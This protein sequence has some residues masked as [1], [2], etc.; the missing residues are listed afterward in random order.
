MKPVF[1]STYSHY[2]IVKKTRNL[3]TGPSFLALLILLSCYR[4]LCLLF[5]FGCFFE[6]LDL[7]FQS[8]DHRVVIFLHLLDAEIKTF[9]LLFELGFYAVFL[10]ACL[11]NLT[12]HVHAKLYLGSN[13]NDGIEEFVNFGCLEINFAFDDHDEFLL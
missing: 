11:G 5:F 3:F 4:L 2:T 13:S 12:L 9:A 6:L 8:L 1:H 10:P 7:G